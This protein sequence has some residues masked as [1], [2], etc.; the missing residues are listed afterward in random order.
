MYAY[1]MLFKYLKCMHNKCQM[2]LVTFAMRTFKNHD[3]L[4]KTG[5]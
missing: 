4:L 5:S 2:L 3:W 1:I